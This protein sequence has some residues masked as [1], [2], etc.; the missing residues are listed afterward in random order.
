[1]VLDQHQLSDAERGVQTPGRVGHDER[2]GPQRRGQARDQRR[3]ADPVALV[4]MH[5]AP[6]DGGG[7]PIEIPEHQA[8]HVTLHRRG[9]KAREVHVRELRAGRYVGYDRVA[10]AGA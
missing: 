1:M 3:G 5:A 2:I 7:H 6:E 8:P 9:W 4:Q 10:E